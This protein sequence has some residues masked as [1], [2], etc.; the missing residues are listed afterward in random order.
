MR[1]LV[2]RKDY[3]PERTSRDYDWRRGTGSIF[4]VSGGAITTT[5]RSSEK[6]R[7]VNSLS[8]GSVLLCSIA[9][10]LALFF[11]SSAFAQNVRE[12]Y[13]PPENVA[14][15]QV[16]SSEMNASE[17]LPLT[18][19][20]CAFTLTPSG[21]DL[22]NFLCN[23]EAKAIAQ[24]DTVAGIVRF[25]PFPSQNIKGFYRLGGTMEYMEIP[26]PAGIP[27]HT[28]V[29]PVFFTPQAATVLEN[30]TVLI[31]GNV[32][33]GG[34]TKRAALFDGN[35]TRFV[36][37]EMSES[38]ITRLNSNGWAIIFND[39][40]DSAGVCDVTHVPEG[41]FVNYNGCVLPRELRLADGSV[42][43]ANNDAVA[44]DLGAGEDGAPYSEVVGRVKISS[45]N[46]QAFL[47]RPNEPFLRILPK[48]LKPNGSAYISVRELSVLGVPL[49]SAPGRRLAWGNFDSPEFSKTVSC[50][51]DNSITTHR[52]NALLSQ[53][54][55]E[56][57]ELHDGDGF[58]SSSDG[59][60]VAINDR[61]EVVVAVRDRFTNQSSYNP[62]DFIARVRLLTSDLNGD[63]AVTFADVNI[64]ISF[65]NTNSDAGDVDGDGD[66][67]FSDLN[68]IVSDWGQDLCNE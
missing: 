32:S 6:R 21:L 8:V 9:C 4:C 39:D 56:R 29:G 36:L 58:P 38:S 55:K 7:E 68:R 44:L 28:S 15:P 49:A 63:L 33:G 48:I 50:I 27:S 1:R 23:A 16:V 54:D 3:Q 41:V 17:H 10:S 11:S 57:Y 24:D 30:G 60:R 31:G 47:K 52:M 40:E 22:D 42:A 53:A 34:Y 59:S 67:D 14:G 19:D 18:I 20:D 43:V 12:F 25:Y 13:R 26:L 66:T 64:A 51:T 61:G 37:A 5:E 46:V 35:E 2:K 62:P 65:L 45:G